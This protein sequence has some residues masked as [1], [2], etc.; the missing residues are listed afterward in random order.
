MIHQSSGGI[1]RLFERIAGFSSGRLL[2]CRWEDLG[3]SNTAQSPKYSGYIADIGLAP[4]TGAGGSTLYAA[5]VQS[6]AGL[7][8][9]RTTR[10]VA[11]DLP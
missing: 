4:A 7:N 6:K 8:T 1:G 10:V 3:L 5:L 11:Y 2:A 9:T